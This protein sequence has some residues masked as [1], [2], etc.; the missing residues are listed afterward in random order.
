MRE[1]G[2]DFKSF[3]S[4]QRR[5][6]AT[7]HCRNPAILESAQKNCHFPHQ[8]STL[9]SS[10]ICAKCTSVFDCF[11]SIKIVSKASIFA[12]Y[13]HDFTSCFLTP[14]CRKKMCKN[15]RSLQSVYIMLHLFCWFLSVDKKYVKINDFGKVYT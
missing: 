14:F 4:A 8:Q 12:K 2:C 6:Y 13:T 3:S 10:M 15:Q 5:C 7:L 9:Q 11:L 1:N